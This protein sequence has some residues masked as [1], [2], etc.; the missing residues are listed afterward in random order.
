MSVTG[1]PSFPLPHSPAWGRV[2]MQIKFRQCGTAVLVAHCQAL[3]IFF[4]NARRYRE[5]EVIHARWAM[6]GALGCITP[7][8]LQSNGVAKF[9]EP[10][11][12]KAGAQI[13]SSGGGCSA[14]NA[15]SSSVTRLKA[16]FWLAYSCAARVCNRIA[17]SMCTAHT[18]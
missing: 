5:I 14:S 8:L 11:W 15:P 18:C 4:E 16:V 1:L 7:E 10:V 9:Q 6:L 2:R 3:L 12:W 17:P 13:F